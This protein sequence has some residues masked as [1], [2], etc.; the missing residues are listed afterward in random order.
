MMPKVIKVKNEFEGHFYDEYI[1][2]EGEGLYA[3][4]AGTELKL[5]GKGKARIDG[6]ERVTGQARFTSDIQLPGML[7]GKIL[8]SPLPH[9]K[10]KTIETQRAEGVPGVRAVLTYQNIPPLPFFEGQT[11]IFDPTLRYVGDE[12]ACV[13]AEE[14]EIC[15]DAIEKIAVEYEP[16]PFVLDA[17]EALRPDAPRLHP[18]GNLWRGGPDL[19]ERGSL[20]TGFREAEVIVEEVFKTQ[21][22]LHNCLETHGSVALWEGDRLTLWDST[23]NIF[24]VRSQ[25]AA[26]LNL[27]LDKVR[28]IKKYMGGGFGSKNSMGKYTILAAIGARRTGR[29]VKILL[30]RQEENLAAGNRPASTQYLK[31]GAK[32][33]GALTALHLR[34]YTAAGAF[35]LGAPAVGGPVRQLYACPN[36][37]TEQYLVFTN[38][39]PLS[40]FRGPGYVEGTFALESIMDELAERL[41]MDPLS[42]RLKNYTDLN[43]M[44]GKPYSTKGL[45]EAYTAGAQKIR[46]EDHPPEGQG[47]KRRGR[48]MASQVWGGSGGP[49]AYALVKINPDGSVTVISGTQDLGTGTKTVLAQIAAEE[50]GLEME[51]VSVE[52]GDT[53]MAPYAPLSAGSMTLP[54]VGPAVRVAAHDARRQLLEVAAQVLE[55]PRDSLNIQE[56]LLRS[57]ALQ[58]PVPI[59]DLLSNVRNFMIIGQGARQPNPEKVHVNTF[60]AQFVELEVDTQTGEVKIRKVVA[61]H[62]SGRVINPLT[63]ASQITGG[64]LQGLGFALTERRFIDRRT[65]IVVNSNLED[66]K[67]PTCLDV[68]AVE[69]EMVDR[70]DLQA[71]NL[72]SKGVGEPPIIPTAAA[73]ANALADALKVRIKELPIT[74][75]KVLEALGHRRDSEARQV[76]KETPHA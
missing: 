16:L 44:T 26:L 45:R 14:E 2:V 33:D 40:A 25:A 15:A 10:I 51:K 74:R 31:A 27:P 75:E 69:Q 53:Q 9:G 5:V 71:N 37:K 58:K 28:V 21:T 19:Y 48:G 46:W 61:V 20:E 57:P 1:V 11:F 66:Y 63:L 35:G 64:V 50:L 39:G 7:Y 6:R 30:D 12:I 72:G 60:G 29:A 43:P 36:V 59:Q 41:G 3:W 8:R 4:E 38:T 56:G 52:L 49:P 67:I 18:G 55:I 13:I 32:R 68:P 17:E 24:G 65:G 42:L 54:S 73:V 34:A 47:N 23:Q 76:E 62:D 22:A 70:P